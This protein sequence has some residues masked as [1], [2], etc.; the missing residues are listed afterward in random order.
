MRFCGIELKT[1]GG[2]CRVSTAEEL[3]AGFRLVLLVA[4]QM[5]FSLRLNFL[6]T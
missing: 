6:V 5:S 4:L 2:E 1:C 3:T